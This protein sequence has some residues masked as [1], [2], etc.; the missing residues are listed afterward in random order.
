MPTSDPTARPPVTIRVAEPHE[1]DEIADLL[2][3][4][5]V[6]AGLEQ[7]RSPYLAVLRDVAGHAKPGPV[8]VAERSGALVGTVTICPHGS[9]FSELALP[10]EVEFRFLA[11][12]SS[13]WGTG[14]ADDLVRACEQHGRDVGAAGL[15]ICVL[16]RNAAAHGLYARHGFVRV[17]ERDFKPVPNVLLQTSVKAL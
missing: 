14:I 11:V 6:D 10:G 3:S 8:L 4:A 17:P 15:A 7:E 12:A 13:A 2:E 9:R 5:Y 16:A 1:Y